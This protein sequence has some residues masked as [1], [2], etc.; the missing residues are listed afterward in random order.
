MKVVA[1]KR[2]VEQF[3]NEQMQQAFANVRGKN[4][5]NPIR[6]TIDNPGPR[7]VE[8]LIAAIVEFTGSF[9]TVVEMPNGK[10]RVVADGYYL[11]I[12]A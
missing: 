11:A 4:W 1:M 8:C 2:K 9:P 10:L 12:G 7:N 5:K 3:S 6:K